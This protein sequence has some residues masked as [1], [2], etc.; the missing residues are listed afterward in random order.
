MNIETFRNYCLS[1]KGVREDFPFDET[2][3]VFKIGS[4]MFALTDIESL[5][6]SVNL[7]CEP[8]KAIELREQYESITP[9]W[10]MNKKHWNTVCPDSRLPL[11]LFYEMVDNSYNLVFNSL[12]KSEK[13]EI[14]NESAQAK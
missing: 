14:D 6:F 8:E 3:I 11:S 2:T 4:K 1:K 5:P 12:K 10:H 13:L 9:G 7:K